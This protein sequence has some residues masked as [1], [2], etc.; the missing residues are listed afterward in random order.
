MRRKAVIGGGALVLLLLTF[1][2]WSVHS[3]ARYQRHVQP[4]REALWKIDAATEAGVNRNDYVKLLRSAHLEQNRAQ[5]TL[6]HADLQR[7][8]W[9]R[10][11]AALRHYDS[12]SDWWQEN[13]AS[14]GAK[15]GAAEDS[16]HA[17]WMRA[18]IELAGATSS[19]RGLYSVVYDRPGTVPNRWEKYGQPD[20]P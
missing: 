10:L 18:E 6:S 14:Y 20:S 11:I 4:F 5:A 7:G 16:L 9:H 12:A 1:S 3:N 8:S 15:A 17:E 19:M 13:I 2:G